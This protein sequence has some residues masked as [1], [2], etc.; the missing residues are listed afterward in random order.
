ML[1]KQLSN[2]TRRLAVLE[3]PPVEAKGRMTME[4]R[5][6]ALATIQRYNQ[7][8]PDL[9]KRN[10]A[11]FAALPAMPSPH[12]IDGVHLNGAGYQAW[13]AAVMQ[14]AAAVCG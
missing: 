7:A 9:A 5:D 12:T 1:L 8:L 10:G 14:A 2:S 6:T 11:A 4:M 13:D 3:V